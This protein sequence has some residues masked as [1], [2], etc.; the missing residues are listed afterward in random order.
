MT[1]FDVTYNNETI[2]ITS[3]GDESAKFCRGMQ[4]WV[5]NVAG[6]LDVDDP[7]QAALVD[8]AEEGTMLDNLRFYVDGTSYFTVDL[9]ADS[10]AGCIIDSYN[11]TADNNSVVSFTMSVT[12]SGPLKRYP[13][14]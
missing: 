12:G 3:F 7:Q 6:H 14:T 5:A 9:V 4:S 11:F 8:A 10:E 2:D 13:S 1:S